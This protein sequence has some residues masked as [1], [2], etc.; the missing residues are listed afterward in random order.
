[1]HE[2]VEVTPKHLRQPWYYAKWFYCTN[3]K[4]KTTMIMPDRYRVFRGDRQAAC[5]GGFQ[6]DD[7]VMAMLSESDTPWDD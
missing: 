4:C 6:N 1:V 5:S 3:P 7:I 2:H